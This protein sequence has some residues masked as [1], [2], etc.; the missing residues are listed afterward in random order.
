MT[1]LV[2]VTGPISAGTRL[3]CRLVDAS[4]DLVGV[5]DDTHG[6][7]PPDAWQ[8]PYA[9]LVLVSR[10]PAAAD[11][12]RVAAWGA[13]TMTT[14]QLRP[15]LERARGVVPTIDVA[16]EQVCA[17][18]AAVVATLADWLGVPAWPFT[19]ACPNQNAK[20]PAG[21]PQLHTERAPRTIRRAPGWE[22]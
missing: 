20:W 14:A 18:P 9:A 21:G 7:M 16:Y 11:A 5:H 4:P 6:L 12:S 1:A 10:D 13:A 19:E 17:D 15:Y 8:E 22:T 3:V 2:L